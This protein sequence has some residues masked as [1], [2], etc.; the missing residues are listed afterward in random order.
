MRAAIYARYSTDKR[1]DGVDMVL[2]RY[3]KAPPGS[4]K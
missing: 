2:Q 4:K 3:K 1:G